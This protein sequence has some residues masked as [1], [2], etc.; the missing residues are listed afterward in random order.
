MEVQDNGGEI[1]AKTLGVNGG[2]ALCDDGSGI[3]V[4]GHGGGIALGHDGVTPALMLGGEAMSESIARR[5]A[6]ASVLTNVYGVTEAW[7][8]SCAAPDQHATRTAST[9][10]TGAL[11]AA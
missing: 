8:T 4:G 2:M 9:V 3:A 10:Q 6:S 7:P 5:W 11:C 1:S